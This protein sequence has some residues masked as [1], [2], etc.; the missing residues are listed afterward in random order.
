MIHFISRGVLARCKWS[1]SSQESGK[2]T[3]IS[4]RSVLTEPKIVLTGAALEISFARFMASIAAFNVGIVV[5]CPLDRWDWDSMVKTR[6]SCERT[7]RRG[8]GYEEGT[9]PSWG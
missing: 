4:V 8:E 3:L 7:V 1:R 2:H 5:S 9:E 6:R